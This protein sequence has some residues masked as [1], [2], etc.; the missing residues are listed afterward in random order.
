MA[1][2]YVLSFKLNEL[3]VKTNR[4]YSKPNADI[5]LRALNNKAIRITAAPAI[6]CQRLL[7]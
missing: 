7:R 5:K 4:D 1:G 6:F 2:L 3:F